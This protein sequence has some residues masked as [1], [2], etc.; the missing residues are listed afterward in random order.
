V[1]VHGFM[2][3]VLQHIPPKQFR[4]VR[5]YGAYSRRKSKL[6]KKFVKQSTIRQK[7]L[8]DFDNNGLICSD[9]GEVME[10]LGYCRKPPPRDLSKIS[11]W[12]D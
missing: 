2:Y 12:I 5:Y 7:I 3:S 1:N 10:I 9:C 8:G 4:M 6:I 11:S